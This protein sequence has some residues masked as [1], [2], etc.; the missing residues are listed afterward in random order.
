MAVMVWLVALVVAVAAVVLLRPAYGQFKLGI[1]LTKVTNLME[2]AL[3][4]QRAGTPPP[5]V[6]LMTTSL[7][8]LRAYPRHVITRELIKN[9]LLAL[10]MGRPERANSIGIVLEMLVEEGVAL[11]AEAFA[12]SYA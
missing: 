10:Q 6:H 5:P 12:Q 11:D 1:H 8:A 3:A 2:Q 7:D 9:S 4:C